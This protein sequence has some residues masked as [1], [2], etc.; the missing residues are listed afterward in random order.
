MQEIG[1]S[2]I[3]SK[4]R[5]SL[6]DLALDTRIC[7][8]HTTTSDALWAGVPVVALRGRHFASRV[9]ASLLEGHTSNAIG[10]L[11]GISH[12]TVEV[13]RARLMRKYKASTTADLVHKLMAG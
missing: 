4:L 5:F 1:I 13:Y 12:R 9:A 3:G 8:G 6:C 10:R 7:N 2:E 11:L